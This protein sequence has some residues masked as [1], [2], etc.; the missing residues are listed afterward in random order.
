MTQTLENTA[1]NETVQYHNLLDALTFVEG[2]PNIQAIAD[3]EKA[4]LKKVTLKGGVTLKCHQTDCQVVV[5]WL[6]GKAQ[7]IAGDETFTMQP[8]TL[9]EMPPGT[10]H[11]ATA[12]TDCVFAVIKVSNGCSKSCS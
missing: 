10:P 6:R 5:I 3:Y 4:Q 11:G 7:F 8:G 9:L 12:E 1:K 2:K